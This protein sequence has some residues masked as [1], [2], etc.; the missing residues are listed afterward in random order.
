MALFY[1]AGLLMDRLGRKAAIVPSFVIQAVGMALIPLA[2]SQGVLLAVASLIGLGTGLGSG[3]MMTLGADLAPRETRGE[4]LG[5]W[6]LI[7]DGGSS[8]GPLLVG[9]VSDLLALPA[10][11]LVMAVAGRGAGLIFAL[12]VPERGARRPSARRGRAVG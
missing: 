10:A 8:L 2:H 1:P 6:R 9:Q 12:G 7:G 3:S 11:A 5:V 4:F